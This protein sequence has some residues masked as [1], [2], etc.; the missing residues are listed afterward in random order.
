MKS[1][2]CG[3]DKFPKLLNV[4][5]LLILDKIRQLI[6]FLLPTESTESAPGRDRNLNGSQ[7]VFLLNLSLVLLLVSHSWTR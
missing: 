2:R 1:Q 7:R 5:C 4:W 3:L 6:E